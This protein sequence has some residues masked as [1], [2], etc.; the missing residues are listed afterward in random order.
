MLFLYGKVLRPSQQ[1][2]CDEIIGIFD[3]LFLRELIDEIRDCACANNRQS[4]PA[5]ALDEGVS[6][7]EENAYLKN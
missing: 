7:L 3:Q 2:C 6:A 5:A 1:V 4:D